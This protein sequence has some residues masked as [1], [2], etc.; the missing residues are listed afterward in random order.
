MGILRFDVILK[1]IKLGR[2]KFPMIGFLLFSFGALLAILSG[3][4]FA[5]D[6]FILGYAILFAAN[7]SV[8]YSNDYFDFEVDKYG[9]PTAVSGGSG[10]LVQ[11]PE[12]REFAKWFAIVLMSISMAFAIV[13]TISFSFPTF[14]LLFV[15]LGNLLGWFY[16]AP[17]FRLVYRGFSEITAIIAVGL[18]MPGIGYFVFKGGFDFSFIVFAL[19]SML[20]A[21][22]FIISVEIPDMEIDGLGLKNTIIVREG[23]KFGFKLITLS[24][25]FSTL[26][27]LAISLTNLFQ[28]LIDFRLTTLFS[29]LPLVIGIFGL[30]KQTDDKEL[31]TR[32]VI[33][34]LLVFSLFLLII[35][36]YFILLFVLSHSPFV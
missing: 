11:N 26:Y 22:A 17:P 19:P 23:R 16:T 4:R 5:L 29:L 25:S 7:L 15:V 9:K 18:F 13:F 1:I 35:D 27:F 20:Y 30:G 10:I 28:S 36:C 14:F 2:L 8:S 24:L 3:V 6:R 12:L 21:L 31:A 34:N 33:Y 32:L